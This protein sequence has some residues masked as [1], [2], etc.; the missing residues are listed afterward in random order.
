MHYSWFSKEKATMVNRA[1]KKVYKHLRQIREVEHKVQDKVKVKSLIRESSGIKCNNIITPRGR[2]SWTFSLTK[3][4]RIGGS[5]FT[6]CNSLGSHP[7]IVNPND[8]IV[9]FG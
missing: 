3:C 1:T 2:P 9:N 6:G 5:N 4:N 7:F 8:L